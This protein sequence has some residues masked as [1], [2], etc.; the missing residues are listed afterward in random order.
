MN[1]ED[2]RD[3]KA[4]WAGTYAEDTPLAF[5]LMG[6]AATGTGRAARGCRT[7]GGAEEKGMNVTHH[8]K[9]AA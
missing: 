1:G 6:A 5:R 3:P 2:G 9:I 4:D 7:S 8:L